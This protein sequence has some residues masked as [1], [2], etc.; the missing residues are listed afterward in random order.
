MS[1]DFTPAQKA[2]I[3]NRG[4]ALLVSAAAGSGKTRVLTERLLRYVEGGEDVD[5]FLVITFTR[6]AAA[7]LRCRV[8]E[9]LSRAAAAR[10]EDVRLRRQQTLCCRARIGTI[11]S[12]CGEV[13]RE[14]CHLLNIPPN[15]A[16]LEEDRAEQIKR[17]VLSRLLE[18]RYEAISEDGAFRALVDTVGAGRDD[19]RLEETVLALY[20]RLRAYPDMAGWAARQKAALEAAEIADAGETV[21]GAEILAE[22]RIH[23]AEQISAMEA[24]RAGIA[25]AGGA[26]LKAYGPSFDVTLEAL[27]ELQ[28]GLDQG[29]DAAAARAKEIP[30]PRLGALRNFDDAE[31][32][33]RVT[34]ARDRCKTAAK[35]W[36]E[37]FAQSSEAALSELRATAPAMGALLDLTGAL[38]KAFFKEKL[39]RGGLDFSDLEQCAARLLVSQSPDGGFVP[40]AVAAEY[41]GRFREIMVDEYQDVSPVQELIFNAVSDHGKNLFLVGDVKQS[42]YRFRSA[43]PALFLEKYR[44]WP[45]AGEVEPGS[46]APRR[47]LLRE[48]FRSRAAV[49]D[50]VNGV[51]SSIMSERLGELSYDADAALIPGA[52]CYPAGT[53]EP[54]ELVLVE[55]EASDG[56]DTPPPEKSR[57]EARYVAKRIAGMMRSGTLVHGPDGPRRCRW[58]DFVILLRS[59]G[60]EQFRLALAEQGIPVE[61][62]GGGGYFTGLEITVAV[63][64][65]SL[66]DNPHAD[67]PLISV[68][69]SP[70]FGFTPDELSAVRACA[71]EADFFRAVCAAAEGGDEKCREFLD[72]LGGWRAVAPDISPDALLWRVCA[73]TDLLAVCAA[74]ADGEERLRRLDALFEYARAFGESGRR[75]LFRFLGW[76]RR[77]AEEDASPAPGPGEDAVRITSIHKSKGLEYPFVFLC[78]LHR[79]FNLSDA[80]GSVLLHG[81]LGLGPKYTDAALGAEW[82]SIAHRAIAAR[83]TRETLS[84]EMRVLYVAMTR[85][86]EKLVMTATKADAE[87]YLASLRSEARSPLPPGLLEGAADRLDWLARAALPEG[88]GIAVK[89][90]AA[91]AETEGSDASEATAEA[92]AGEAEAA[93]GRVRQKLSFSYPYAAAAD[94]PSKLTATELKRRDEE[95]DADAASFVEPRRE[96]HKETFRAPALDGEKPLSAAERGSAAHRFLQYLDYGRTDTARQLAAEAARLAAAGRLSEA[97]REAL[98]LGA[99]QKLFASPLGRAMRGAAELRRE[100]RFTLLEDAAAYFPEAPEGDELLL[101]GVVDCFFVEDGGITIIDFKTDHVTAHEAPSRG[102]SYRGQMRAYAAALERILALP[103][104]KT[105]LWFLTPGVEV[106]V[107]L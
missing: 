14:N 68:L 90:V 6:A 82:P 47:I 85:A 101:Q 65:L 9:S 16:V 97:E 19:Q 91:G 2:A 54:A 49:L 4:G 63:N 17:S 1:F 20:E 70:V 5:R 78:D 80:K 52:G 79:R 41:R 88:T 29:W 59:G 102:E 74:M 57:R 30:F 43:E 37:T 12:F 106:E 81:V 27:R 33:D 99:I 107:K 36:K 96:G 66:I 69:R 40:T 86:R 31:L 23:V 48:N 13:V 64:L 76:L 22:A 46:A 58:G 73:D 11:H 56:E 21:W 3:E 93:W 42:I 83:V 67:V 104:R 103:V 61:S 98:D 77:L 10:P 60:G 25:S 45:D 100:F 18:Q 35:G 75:G 72:K 26:I 84:E 92:P 44:A 62:G 89:T 50:A 51:F 7:E 24:A 87:A 34:A 8:M 105:A 53:D 71:P 94:L 55:P 39:R 15:F 38:E 95:A 32:K 28:R